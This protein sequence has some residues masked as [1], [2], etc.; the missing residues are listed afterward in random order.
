[1]WALGLQAAR[2][3]VALIVSPEQCLWREPTLPG[4]GGFVLL[5]SA[6]VAATTRKTLEDQKHY[7]WQIRST[8][9]VSAVQ[10]YSDAARTG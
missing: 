1:M 9:K 4:E 7:G 3:R 5:Q 10:S 8:M 6:I 2:I